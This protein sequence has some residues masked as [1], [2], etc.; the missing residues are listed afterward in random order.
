VA[1]AEALTK[2]ARAPSA[3]CCEAACVFSLASAAAK[4]AGQREAHAGQ[5]LA[6]FRRAQAAGFFKDRAKIER[7]KR[8]SDLAP[9]RSRQDFRE[10][11]AE[12]EA[13]LK[14]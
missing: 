9:L 5:A 8:D 11:V 6:L 13:A 3:R 7:L 10:L 1:D 12:L 14:P 2:D 4:D